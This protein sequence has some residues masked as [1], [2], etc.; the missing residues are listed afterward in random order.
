MTKPF[1]FL[2]ADVLRAIQQE[3]IRNYRIKANHPLLLAGAANFRYAMSINLGQ[4]IVWSN[5][6]SDVFEVQSGSFSQ[7]NALA[8][9]PGLDRFRDALLPTRLNDSGAAVAG[10]V[11]YAKEASVRATFQDGNTATATNSS[12]S[13]G[14]AVGT[15]SLTSGGT[16]NFGGPLD[17]YYQARGT[18][19]DP[20]TNPGKVLLIQPFEA[21]FIESELP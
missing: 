8:G 15:V 10:V 17:V 3:V 13:W 4:G 6:T 5:A 18:N 11:I 12:T 21:R 7:A 2:G 14:L 16:W 9:V 19:G 1:T 20:E